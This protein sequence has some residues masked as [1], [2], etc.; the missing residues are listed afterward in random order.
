[1]IEGDLQFNF[2]DNVNV[3]KFDQDENKMTYGKMCGVDF[4]IEADD[5]YYF[6][7]IKDPLTSRSNVESLD[8]YLETNNNNCEKII[9]STYQSLETYLLVKFRDTFLYRWAQDKLD[10]DKPVHYIVLINV[11]KQSSLSNL[12]KELKHKLPVKKPENWNKTLAES[13]EVVNIDKWN[14]DYPDWHVSRRNRSA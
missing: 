4:I 1:M 9:S 6:V 2:P 3:I 10:K 11:E 5:K 12:H 8:Q 7:E 14:Q 13:C